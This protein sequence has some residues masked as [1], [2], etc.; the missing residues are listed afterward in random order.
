MICFDVATA[1]DV[2]PNT[3]F[4]FEYDVES[5]AI[6]LQSFSVVSSGS[7]HQPVKTIWSNPLTGQIDGKSVVVPVGQNV[8]WQGSKDTPSHTYSG[9]VTAVCLAIFRIPQT[10]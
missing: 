6:L 8:G 2:L 7:N 3:S 4:D 9:Q 5:F 1:T 10:D